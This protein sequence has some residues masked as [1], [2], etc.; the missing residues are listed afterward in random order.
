M[1]KSNDPQQPLTLQISW[2]LEVEFRVPAWLGSGEGSLLDLQALCLYLQET[3]GTL[4]SPRK[5]NP[6][7]RAP[8]A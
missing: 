1:V 8:G 6:I 2:R 5:A 4:V 3:E 7:K